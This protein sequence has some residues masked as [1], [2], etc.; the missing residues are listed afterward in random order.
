[1]FRVVENLVERGSLA[2]VEAAA[3]AAVVV[4]LLRSSSG[5]MPLRMASVASCDGTRNDSSS[6]EGTVDVFEWWWW[7]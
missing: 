7:A 6:S 3:V 1:M 4:P 2:A 5:M